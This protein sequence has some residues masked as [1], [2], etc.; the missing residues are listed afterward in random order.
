MIKKMEAEDEGRE[1]VPSSDEE[2]VGGEDVEEG[3][4]VGDGGG[5][6]RTLKRKGLQFPTPFTR[7]TAKQKNMINS[8]M[9]LE[10]E[11]A[12]FLKLNA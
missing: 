4:D 9:L 5:G 7:S 11:E 3:E 12:V 6:E 2:E 1:Y 8:E 10:R